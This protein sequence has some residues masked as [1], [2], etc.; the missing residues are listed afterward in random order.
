MRPSIVYNVFMRDFRKQKKRI[1]LTLIALAWGTIS[2][3]LLLAFGEG[4]QR[5]LMVNQKGIGDGIAVLWAG[6]TSI[7][8]K[9]MGKGRGIALHPDDVEYLRTRVPELL[10]VGGEF[11]RWGEKIRYK[12]VF[13]SEHVTGIMPN[14]YQMRNFIP[15][16][17]G[18]M[19]DEG[20][21]KQRRRVVFIGS[22]LKNRLFKADDGIGKQIMING[23]P[24]TVIGVMIPK[25]QMGAY[26]GMDE[27]QKVTVVF[28]TAGT[29]RLKVAY[30][31]LEILEW[32][33]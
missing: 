1:A 12:D 8:Y 29:K 5:Q 4:L 22:S 21:M 16:S 25:M 15:Q 13:L 9:G 10:H 26:E 17:G 2:I 20:D 28:Q 3:M 11:S 24:F 6:Q 7:P 33:S 18:R 31:H 27:D 32:V 14:W 19:I 23:I 30:A